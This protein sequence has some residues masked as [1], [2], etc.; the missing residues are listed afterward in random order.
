MGSTLIPYELLETLIRGSC[1]PSH[2]EEE[3]DA[4]QEPRIKKNPVLFLQIG[5]QGFCI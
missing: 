3:G 2:L 1:A 4:R 5:F